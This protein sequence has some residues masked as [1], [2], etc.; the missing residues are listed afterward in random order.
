[1]SF[2]KPPELPKSEKMPVRRRSTG[3]GLGSR[4]LA[5]VA[6]L[7]FGLVTVLGFSRALEAETGRSSPFA[8]LAM[9]LPTVLLVR[10]ALTG[11]IK[12]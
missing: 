8:S 2:W 9:L 4:L 3:P 12:V 1:M 6:G 5:G 7:A 10:Y 11:K